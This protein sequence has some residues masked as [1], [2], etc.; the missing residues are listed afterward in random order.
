LTQPMSTALIA[1]PVTALHRRTYFVS[2]QQKWARKHPPPRMNM[3]VAG[4][5]PQRPRGIFLAHNLSRIGTCMFGT[6]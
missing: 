2:G 4:K 1:T 3:A 5:K 6:P